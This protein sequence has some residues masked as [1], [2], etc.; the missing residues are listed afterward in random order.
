M[1]RVVP[2]A[3]VLCLLTLTSAGM[4]AQ[5]RG[6]AGA[7]GRPERGARGNASEELL[8]HEVKD[9]AKKQAVCNDGSPAAFY[10][11]PGKDPDRDKW[12]I[13]LQ[14]GAGCGT[15]NDCRKRWN[16][17]HNLMT[18]IG[19]PMR[20]AEEGLF[21]TDENENPDFARY[22]VAVIHYCSS[23]SFAGDAK[24]KLDGRTLQF[25][26][27]RIVDAV[28]D[29]LMD[30]SVVGARTLRQATEV[31]FAGTSAGGMGM[32]NNLDRVAARLSWAHVKGVADS[33]WMPDV[34][35][36]GPGTLEVAP[37]GPALVDYANAQPDESCAAANPTQKGRCLRED[38]LYPYL[39]TPLFVYADQRD[40]VL[41]GVLGINGP[42]R[43]TAE[44]RY[45]DSYGQRLREQLKDLPGV[46]SPSINAHTSLG[47][48]RFHS[49]T[50]DGQDL[51][52][53]LGNWYFDRPGP[54]HLI[55][56]AT[57]ANGRTRGAIGDGAGRGRG[58]RGRGR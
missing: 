38:F 2:V 20:R 28:L 55:A 44:Q 51:A 10:F 19:A 18:S 22:T 24:R 39:S 53:T 52:T 11:R 31:M 7:A 34:A 30:S 49:V 21:S 46:F 17:E 1:K 40:P 47:T 23:D 14:G 58:A 6:R 25:R 45:I 12:I 15:D 9:A 26:G 41:L 13:F 5:R 3:L 36:F 27:H 56:P 4:V 33:S 42:A 37:N 16:D 57:A 35:P 29:D 48:E 43:S 8:K 50:I 32:H 54:K